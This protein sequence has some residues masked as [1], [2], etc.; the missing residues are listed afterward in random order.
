MHPSV[1]NALCVINRLNCT[2][3]SR[4]SYKLLSVHNQNIKHGRL[5]AKTPGCKT[6]FGYSSY[7]NFNKCAEI[8]TECHNLNVFAGFSP[9]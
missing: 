6:L 7:R 5:L 9:I 1:Q 4:I 2:E 8:L 3:K